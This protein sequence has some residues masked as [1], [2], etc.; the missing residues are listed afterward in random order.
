[1]SPMIRDRKASISGPI[2]ASLEIV[3][4]DLPKSS[5]KERYGLFQACTKSKKPI[6]MIAIVKHF[7]CSLKKK[8]IFRSS[9]LQVFVVGSFRDRFLFTHSRCSK[10][11]PIK[12][13]RL[14]RTFEDIDKFVAGSLMIFVLIPPVLVPPLGK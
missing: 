2:S 10:S 12:I 7:T 4:I 9:I 5:W 1:M 3:L 6:L 11:R 14:C 13:L 8:K